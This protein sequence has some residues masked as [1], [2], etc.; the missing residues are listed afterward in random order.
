M[1]ETMPTIIE[2]TRLSVK[3]GVERK[4]CIY[5]MEKLPPTTNAE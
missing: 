4:S 1:T 2:F 5:V 3:R